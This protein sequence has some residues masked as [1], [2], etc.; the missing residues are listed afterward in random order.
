[1]KV[2]NLKSVK[3]GNSA[4]VHLGANVVDGPAAHQKYGVLAC[5]Q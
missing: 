2:L 3:V 1:M 4:T 5:V